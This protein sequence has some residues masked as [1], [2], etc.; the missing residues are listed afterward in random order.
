MLNSLTDAN[1]T[2]EKIGAI[3]RAIAVVQSRYDAQMA[4][5]KK[6][7]EK[8]TEKDQ[9]ELERL[10]NELT[11]FME[12]DVS[13]FKK[14]K[15]IKLAFGSLISRKN[16]ARL[17]LDSAES[18]GMVLDNLKKFKMNRFIETKKS[19]DKD[20]IKKN[21]ST[22]DMIKIGVKKVQETNYKFET[23]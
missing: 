7:M 22:D 17:E 20:A 9:A 1:Q 12:S 18:W 11:E 16:P 13:L 10:Q 6:R 19:P 4:E 3:K 14:S 21:M 8:E 2:L 23:I 5:I 15:T